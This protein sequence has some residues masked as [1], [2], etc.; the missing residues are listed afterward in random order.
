MPRLTGSTAP[1]TG[2]SWLTISGR[3][4]FGVKTTCCRLR[5]SA[6]IEQLRAA[7]SRWRY[8]CDHVLRPAIVSVL[9]TL[10]HHLLPQRSP[11]LMMLARFVSALVAFTVFVY[12]MSLTSTSQ[13]NPYPYPYSN[14]P[15]LLHPLAPPLDPRGELESALNSQ[16]SHAYLVHPPVDDV[17]LSP[18]YLVAPDSTELVFQLPRNTPR[19][20]TLLLHGCHHAATDFF[21]PSPACPHCLG[22]P[23]EL[24]LVRLAL[25]RGHAVVAVSSSNRGSGC[26]A[27][28]ATHPTGPDYDRIASA[29]AALPPTA[30]DAPLFAAGAS[31]GGRFATSLSTPRFRVAAVCSIVSSSVMPRRARPSGSGAGDGGGRDEANDEGAFAMPHAF[32]HM[33]QRDK[34]IAK[35]VKGTA[36]ALRAAGVLVAEFVVAPRVLTGALLRAAMP[37]WGAGLA[38]EVVEALRVAGH[39]DDAGNVLVDPRRSQWRR[40]VEHLKGLMNDS[41]VADKS[42]LSEVLNHAWAQ[43][44]ISSEH[45]ASVLDFFEE[46]GGV[47][48]RWSAPF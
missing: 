41:L 46:V 16:S 6:I 9:P 11:A 26:W 15:D 48:S 29:L 12:G 23:E 20:T 33:A 38:D 4:R 36:A 14:Y 22:L 40:A 42:P 3:I 5:Q 27:T 43:H 45:F 2:A 10:H 35:R 47:T 44:E 17:S 1:K 32:V 31:S 39:I 8:A 28:N 7:V 18:T 34:A 30:R 21:P 19:A 25:H 13:P 37:N 24:R